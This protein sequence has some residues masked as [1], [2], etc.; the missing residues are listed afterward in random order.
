[1]R[2]QGITPLVNETAKVRIGTQDIWLAGLDDVTN[3]LPALK[4]LAASCSVDDFV[5][6]LSHNPSVIT[7][8]L[9]AV[10]KKNRRGWFDLGLFGHTHGGQIPV[11]SG[12][13]GMPAATGTYRRGWYHPNK[14]DL[15]VS[16]GVGT[17]GI[18]L[19]LGCPPQL[20]VITVISD[21]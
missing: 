7:E 11:L 16:E 20:H 19:R 2:Q 15:L 18:P 21:K 17:S 12:S 14:L 6:F 9:S 3:G 1:M 13:L 4:S 8:A 10:D 5:I